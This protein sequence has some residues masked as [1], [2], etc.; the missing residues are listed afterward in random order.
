MDLALAGNFH[1]K[2]LGHR[3][4]ALGAHPVRASG[5]G[6]TSLPIL[7]AG[8]QRRQHQFDAR[9]LVFGMKVNWNPA[10]VVADGNGAIHVDGDV[11]VIAVA[12]QVLI[13]GVVKHFR[14]A[15]VQGPFVGAADVHARLLADSFEPLQF[16]ELRRAIFTRRFRRR[17][18]VFR[19]FKHV[20][21]R[22]KIR[23]EEALGPSVFS[24]RILE[25]I[26]A[27]HNRYF[28]HF[29]IKKYH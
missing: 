5:I 14:H 4:D 20:F 12:G 11:N 1:R 3:V 8:V 17:A 22:H 2:P 7:A 18:H 23:S 27:K 6:V 9:N 24:A 25:K 29:R 28:P 26:G 10:P 21:F 15:V 16:P 13:H 19:R